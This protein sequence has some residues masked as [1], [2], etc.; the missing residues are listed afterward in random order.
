MK[1][2]STFWVILHS[3]ACR[4][5]IR[6]TLSLWVVEDHEICNLFLAP[7]SQLCSV[8]GSTPNTLLWCRLFSWRYIYVLV[9][10]EWNR[11]KSHGEYGL[12]HATREFCHDHRD[13]CHAHL[14]FCHAHLDHRYCTYVLLA[15]APCTP[16]LRTTHYAL[17]TAHREILPAGSTVLQDSKYGTTTVH[18]HC[19]IYI[20]TYHDTWY[21]TR[22]CITVATLLYKLYHMYCTVYYFFLCSNSVN[23]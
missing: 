22:F 2:G 16:Q 5:S 15:R 17:R 6:S 18:I 9:Q 3:H 19:S 23:M 11:A 4:V 21:S 7:G 14:E 13:L 1:K 20:Q 8:P 12:G 10:I